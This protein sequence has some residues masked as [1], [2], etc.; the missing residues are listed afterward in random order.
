MIQCPYCQEYSQ[1][2]G[3]IFVDITGTCSGED[4]C[5]QC[6]TKFRYSYCVI[7]KAFT[8]ESSRREQWDFDD[9]VYEGLESVID[10]IQVEDS[11]IKE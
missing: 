10:R 8:L 9:L 6:G 4:I 5:S 1:L 3:V 2:S 11:K 7:G